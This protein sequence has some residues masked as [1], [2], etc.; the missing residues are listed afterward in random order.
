MSGNS[1]SYNSHA[2]YNDGGY[3]RE[4][5][6]DIYTHD[7]FV[8]NVDENVNHY[9]D[10]V[11]GNVGYIENVDNYAD[12]VNEKN[13]SG[14]GHN[15]LF[16]ENLHGALVQN[17]N[18]ADC[19][20]D[21]WNVHVNVLVDNRPPRSLKL[22]I[23]TGARCNVMSLKTAQELGLMC[24]L[25]NNEMFVGGIHGKAVKAMGCITVPCRYKGDVHNMT[26]EVL[27]GA[28][29]IDLIGRPDI[30]KFGLVTRVNNVSSGPC[31][32]I[33]S[34]FSDVLGNAI[35]CMP[36]EYTIKVDPSRPAVQHAPRPVPV[37]IR[38]QV[39]A[40]LCHL[41]SKNIIAKVE[42]P[43]EWVSS[44]VCVRKKSGRVRICIDPTDLNKAV[45]REHYPM[46][47]IEDIVTRLHGSTVFST[48]DANMGYFQIKLSRVQ[49]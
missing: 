44:M 37:P 30:R 8:V 20:L 46:G 15:V 36:G 16:Q 3:S 12:H 22:E 47:S 43:T 1:D 29:R 33:V 31:G 35:G 9:D 19:E 45:Q 23:D 40:E 11:H 5:F 10:Y 25:R 13:Q 26:F 32:D 4:T 24:L 41:E 34:R 48:L 18:I 21:E 2:G 38:E 49:I 17:V 27:D 28:K 6:D 14:L 7:V 42:D 39:K